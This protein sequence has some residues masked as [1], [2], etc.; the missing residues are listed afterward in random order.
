MRFD[1]ELMKKQLEIHEGLRLRPY[2]DTVGKLTI[3]VGR[4][5]DDVGLS[6]EEAYLLLDADIARAEKDLD[7]GLP[8]WRQLDPVR[9][10]VLLDMAFN[11]GMGSAAIGKG[12]LSFINTLR[13]VKEERY[14]DAADG[15]MLSMWAQQVKTRAVTLSG[16]MRTGEDAF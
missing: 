11:M 9:Q 5:L 8:W 15:M 13:A 16:M 14:Q 12:L 10:R 4:N 2:R 1:R 3:G 6:R 7:V